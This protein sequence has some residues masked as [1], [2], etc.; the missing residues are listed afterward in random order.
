MYCNFLQDS[1]I[2]GFAGG[3]TVVFLLC[4]I[5]TCVVIRCR[6]AK[7]AANVRIQASSDSVRSSTALTS[8]QHPYPPPPE[9]HCEPNGVS[10]YP[11]PLD[12]A[13]SS[14]DALAYTLEPP[15][16]YSYP[17]ESPPPYPGEERVP[18]YT[19]PENVYQWQEENQENDPLVSAEEQLL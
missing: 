5:V 4:F 1:K 9:E 13:T 7:R 10:S 12:D 14:A 18:P 19:P 17:A 15:P 11:L 3:A 8:S 16:P 2:I 6:K